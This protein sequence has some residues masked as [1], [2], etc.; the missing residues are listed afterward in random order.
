M[1]KGGV[2][3][4]PVNTCTVCKRSVWHEHLG[5]RGEVLWTVHG[6]VAVCCSSYDD[7]G[8]AVD[9]RCIECCVPPAK[10]FTAFTPYWWNA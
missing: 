4:Q 7:N 1:A 3:E 5:L 9:A 10:Q 2:V 6:D 8:N